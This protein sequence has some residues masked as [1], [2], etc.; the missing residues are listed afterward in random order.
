M[1]FLNDVDR[2]E[3]IIDWECKYYEFFERL[4]NSNVSVPAEDQE[5]PEDYLGASEI[6][7]EQANDFGLNGET[8]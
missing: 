5:N 2:H 3:D 1:S 7:N 8:S 6:F 4:P